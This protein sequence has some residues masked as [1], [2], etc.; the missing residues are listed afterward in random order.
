[1]AKTC[2]L[3]LYVWG[4]YV[5]YATFV[6]INSY[7]MS[8]YNSEDFVVVDDANN[9]LIALKSTT[10]VLEFDINACPYSFCS[11]I[12]FRGRILICFESKIII[13]C[14]PYMEAVRS[15]YMLIALLCI[16]T[17]SLV[18][19]TLFVLYKMYTREIHGYVIICSTNV[20][21]IFKKIKKFYVA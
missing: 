10:Q 16:L 11:D 5:T 18:G 4:I 7:N 1:M 2:A 8:K 19:F 12:S 13:E 20:V 9:T 15:N 17:V 21:N 3:V 14:G 6:C